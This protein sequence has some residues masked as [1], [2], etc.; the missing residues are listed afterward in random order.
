MYR[1]ESGIL[2]EVSG[3]CIDEVADSDEHDFCSLDDDSS[4]LEG[5][6]DIYVSRSHSATDGEWLHEGNKTFV[7]L[8]RLKIKLHTC[9]G[10]HEDEEVVLN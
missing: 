4:E 5:R 3:Q 10:L 9:E 7:W 2:E 1:I 8:Q 6:E